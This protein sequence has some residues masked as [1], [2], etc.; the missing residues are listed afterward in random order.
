MPKATFEKLSYPTFSPTIRYPEGIVHN[1]LVEVKE[2]F[3]VADF[4]VLDMEGNLGIVAQSTTEA[5]YVAA[6]SYCSQLL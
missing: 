1:L 5:E 2:T 4:V 6:A 3:I